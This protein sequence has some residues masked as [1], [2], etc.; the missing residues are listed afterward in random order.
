LFAGY[1]D[2]LKVNQ[3]QSREGLGGV[4]IGGKSLPAAFKG[5]SQDNSESYVNITVYKFG[6]KE[7]AISWKHLLDRVIRVILSAKRVHGTGKMVPGLVEEG[8]IG[9][10][11]STVI[12]KSTESGHYASS[13]FSLEQYIS[14]SIE[15][16]TARLQNIDDDD[17]EQLSLMAMRAANANEQ[18]VADTT[19]HRDASKP[20]GRKPV[21]H[22]LSSRS[23]FGS[24]IVSSVLPMNCDIRLGASSILLI[25][26]CIKYIPYELLYNSA[27]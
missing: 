5:P 11:G 12:S 27:N 10:N 3:N 15:V 21:A 4:E 17:Y 23:R 2:L 9:I 19:H 25:P 22:K 16:C 14:S 20:R 7:M 1:Y 24:P 26:S 18:A 13:K 8:Q 6:V